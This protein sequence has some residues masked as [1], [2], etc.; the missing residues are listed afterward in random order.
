LIT[1]IF[2][3]MCMVLK[4]LNPAFIR[5]QD[6]EKN[7][8]EG[9]FTGT[10]AAEKSGYLSGMEFKINPLKQ[11]VIIKALGQVRNTQHRNTPG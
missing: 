9:C 10:V 8:S 5:L 1:G 4:N 11:G 2:T 3:R 6:A 7:L